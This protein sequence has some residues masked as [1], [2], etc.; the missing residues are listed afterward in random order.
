MQGSCEVKTVP[1]N[2][3]IWM[4]E[5]IV[6]TEKELPFFFSSVEI[7]RKVIALFMMKDDAFLCLSTL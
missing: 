2:K 3:N 1:C 7:E 6:M 5:D 4:Y